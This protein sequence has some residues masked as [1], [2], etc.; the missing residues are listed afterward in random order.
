VFPTVDVV[1]PEADGVPETDGVE[2][3]VDGVGRF[4]TG[5]IGTAFGR[6]SCGVTPAVRGFTLG[7]I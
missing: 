6:T 1:V 3:V 7:P 4:A 2:V 5:S